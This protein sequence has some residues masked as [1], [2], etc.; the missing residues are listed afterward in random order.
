MKKFS[1]LFA[2]FLTLFSLTKASEKMALNTLNYSSSF[3]DRTPNKEINTSGK[4][5]HIIKAVKKFKIQ[6]TDFTPHAYSYK[7]LTLKYLKGKLK[8]KQVRIFKT[9]IGAELFAQIA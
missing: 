6:R 7:R 2:A 1:Q 3:R 4:L 5:Y 8:P 9:T